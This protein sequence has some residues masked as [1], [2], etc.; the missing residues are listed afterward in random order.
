MFKYM[1]NAMIQHL[2]KKK[3]INKVK[4]LVIDINLFIS[5]FFS[6]I[7]FMLN[8]SF[9]NIYFQYIGNLNDLI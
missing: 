6:Y 3:Q 7:Y 5:N 2:I 8:E 9:F 4:Y 1:S